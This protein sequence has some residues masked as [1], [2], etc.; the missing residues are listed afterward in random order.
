MH[1]SL[2]ISLKL[3]FITMSRLIVFHPASYQMDTGDFTPQ[4]KLLEHL[5][6]GALPS[7]LQNVLMAY[8]VLLIKIKVR[9][10]IL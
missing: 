5:V 3:P 1:I 9:N 2:F 4:L 8:P 7:L 6:C 10:I